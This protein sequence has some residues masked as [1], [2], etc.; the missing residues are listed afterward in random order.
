M[1]PLA[2][3]L[4]V[5][6]ALLAPGAAR[7]DTAPAHTLRRS[8]AVDTDVRINTYVQYR[9]R[10]CA[11]EGGPRIELRTKPA[12]GTVSLRASSVVISESP[13]GECAGSTLPGLAV[14]Y[15]PQPGYSG[16]DR[17]EYDVFYVKSIAH[18]TSVVDVK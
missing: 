3:A 16:Q 15:T 7:A 10:G 9:A 4:I 17:F 14:W 13:T 1:R 11:A 12:H 5:W 18:E 6:T 8:T 2:L